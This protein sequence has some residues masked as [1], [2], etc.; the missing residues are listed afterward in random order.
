MNELHLIERKFDRLLCLNLRQ[1]LSHMRIFQV[2]QTPKNLK[3]QNFMENQAE[4]VFLY[5]PPRVSPDLLFCN[6][7]TVCE[8]LT[9]R[10]SPRGPF[11]HQSD[12][13]QKTT[14]QQ[15]T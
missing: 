14:Q 5:L 8:H 7:H 11:H 9:D 2:R 12:R 6:F 3:E 1:R 10:K 15:I 4:K 13:I